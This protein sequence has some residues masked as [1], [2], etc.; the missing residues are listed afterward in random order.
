MIG[1]N[2]ISEELLYFNDEDANLDTPRVS[3]SQNEGKQGSRGGRK[4]T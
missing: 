1:L 2:Q 4:P 3:L